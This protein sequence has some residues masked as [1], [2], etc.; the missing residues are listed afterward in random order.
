ML[1]DD[2]DNG[3]IDAINQ[4][5]QGSEANS[6]TFKNVESFTSALYGMWNCKDINVAR[7]RKLYLLA[8]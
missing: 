7:R 3:W 1:Q 2:E 8:G 6:S 4:L 5:S